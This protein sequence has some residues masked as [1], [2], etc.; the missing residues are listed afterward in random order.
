[1][2]LEVKELRPFRLRKADANMLLDMIQ[3]HT[4][5]HILRVTRELP[6]ME[7][8][9][10]SDGPLTRGETIR[11]VESLLAMHGIGI[12][13]ISEKFYKAVRAEKINM[14][15][16]IWLEGE[17]SAIKPSQKIYMKM[18]HLKYAPVVEVVKNLTPF[19][20]EVGQMVP[21]ENSNSIL[22]TDAL[23]NLQ[24]ME[25]LLEALDRPISTEELGTKFHVWTTKHAGAQELERK[26]K[27]MIDGSL[28]PFLGG[29]T[30]VDSDERTGKLII[31]TR[32]ENLETIDFILETLD[33]PVK[34]K[35][36]S[37]LFKLQHAEALEIQKILD[38]V[39]K[40]QQ[41]I[42]QQVQG[43]SAARPALQ[44]AA[45]GAKPAATPAPATQ[46]STAS[47]SEGGGEGAHEFSDFVTISS[48]E[49][50]N[51]ILV[52]GT[53]EDIM[54]I[55]RMIESLDH[56]MPQARLDTIFVMVD[57]IEDHQRGIDALF[58]SLEWSKF[59]RGPR[60]E[61]LFGDPVTEDQQ[62]TTAGPDGLLGT[63][64]DISSTV[65]SNV[66]RNTMQGVLGI[67]GL[68]TAVPFQL[69][70]WKLTGVRWDQ[71]FARAAFRNDVRIFSTPSLSFAHNSAEVSINVEDERTV[72]LPTIVGSNT[73]EGGAR[74]VPQ[75]TTVRASTRLEIKK[76]KIGLPK[77]F[78]LEP[79]QKKRKL[80]KPGSIF[81]NIQLKAEKFAETGGAVYGDQTIPPKKIREAQ[82]FVTVRDGEI[83]VL[84]GLK[85]FK[86]DSS[87]SKYN[88]LSDI[89]YLGK[90]FFT[91]KAVSYIPSELLIFL[92]PTILDPSTNSTAEQ[93]AEIDKRIRGDYKPAFSTPSGRIL[94]M[95]DIDGKNKN[96]SSSQDRP[97]SRPQL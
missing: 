63:A 49:R 40:N 16:P 48:D 50:S 55:G 26:L 59:A 24:R 12:S 94:G 73:G 92:R 47:S 44:A 93:E 11:V 25:K 54:E 35:T 80:D 18:F 8:N 34:M 46:Q 71:I 37:K 53:K 78:P 9:F 14:H 3:Q 51:A 52:Y 72:I 13:K 57:L 15:V 41:R 90:K 58:G 32:A 62:V 10:N 43:R 56:Q 95:P 81:M 2:G 87:E 19:K 45:A 82:S 42:K 79:G 75:P 91:P 33:A 76:P 85:E 67:P 5:W 6:A 1:V 97:S 4:G 83:L 68:N 60:S 21:L 30:Q 36:T 66:S 61:N 86:V 84:G 88:L 74:E 17:A 96:K 69:E 23:L 77:Y 29:T 89:P 28:K 31:V 7:I 27:G 39:I 70:D 22:V 20:T 38:E 65:V 64:D